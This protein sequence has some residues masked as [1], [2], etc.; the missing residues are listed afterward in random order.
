MLGKDAA[1][2]LVA[3]TFSR[4]RVASAMTMPVERHCMWCDRYE[5]VRRYRLYP[6]SGRIS[7]ILLAGGASGVKFEEALRL[8]AESTE[9]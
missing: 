7:A 9:N 3:A 2:C 6:V 4:M 8:S 5:V 1:R